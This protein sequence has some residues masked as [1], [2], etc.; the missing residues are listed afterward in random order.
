MKVATVTKLTRNVCLVAVVPVLAW[1]HAREPGRRQSKHVDILQALPA[2]RA[3]VRRHGGPALD[4]RRRRPNGL[5]FGLWD[6]SAW[7]HVT[8]LDRRDRS[9]RGLL[10][11]AMASVGLTTRLSVFR[12]LG[13]RPLYLG[14]IA[15][16]LVGVVSLGLA[17]LVGP[18][19][20]RTIGA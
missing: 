4:R 9:P 17:A 3:R 11:T 19:N 8:K 12:G 1:L 5:A 6:A 18:R 13:L 7:T 14:A 16:T 2:L 20:A 10:G 15:A